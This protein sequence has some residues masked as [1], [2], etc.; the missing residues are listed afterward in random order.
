MSLT[1]GV[2][3]ISSD[4][5]M[6][7]IHTEEYTLYIYIMESVSLSA[8]CKHFHKAIIPRFSNFYR[9]WVLHAKFYGNA[10]AI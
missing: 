2:Y 7:Y 5:Q 10:L 1:C 3:E 8:S 4:G 9:F 6:E